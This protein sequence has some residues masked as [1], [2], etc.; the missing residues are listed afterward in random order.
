[1][2][3]FSAS[4]IAVGVLVFFWLLVRYATAASSR[5]VLASL[6]DGADGRPSTSKFQWLVW[7]V[8]GVFAYV[9]VFAERL[10]RG[11]P[12][13]DGAGAEMPQNLIIAMGLGAGTMAV[14]KAVTAS[15][16]EAGLVNKS[17]AGPTQRQG[18]LLCDDRGVPDLSKT[19][20]LAFTLVAVAVYVIHLLGQASSPPIVVDI[21]STLAALLGL[22]QAGY[23]AKKIA[24]RKASRPRAP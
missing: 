12:L 4:L 13:S 18:G 17:S 11:F 1:M 16:A 7:T 20:M 22:S 3:R 2:P 8:V 21:D 6:V 9:Q 14:A 5:G 10:L 15:Y 23:L 19:Q 24:T